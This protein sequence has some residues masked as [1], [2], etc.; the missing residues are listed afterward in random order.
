M[1]GEEGSE[2]LEGFFLTVN[3]SPGILGKNNI[4]LQVSNH[5]E[6]MAQTHKGLYSRE[7]KSRCRQ[8]GAG[9]VFP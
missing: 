2:S 5:Y 6:L 4:Q 9:R 3:W 7:Q 8:Y 1:V